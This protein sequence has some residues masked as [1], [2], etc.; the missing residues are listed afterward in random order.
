[1]ALSLFSHG[2]IRVGRQ[3]PIS[4]PH[5]GRDMQ[6]TDPVLMLPLTGTERMILLTMLRN[7]DR[8]LTKY[9]LGCAVKS[10]H[11]FVNRLRN[12]L[13][14]HGSPWCIDTGPRDSGSYR[15]RKSCSN[16]SPHS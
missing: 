1:M 3:S 12:K 6:E 7:R 14:E 10:A 15:L 2:Q 8:F 11:I 13:R 16:G 4:C 9:Q 5:C